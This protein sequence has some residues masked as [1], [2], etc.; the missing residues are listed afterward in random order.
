MLTSTVFWKLSFLCT[1]SNS[2]SQQNHNIAMNNKYDYHTE[3]MNVQYF[4]LAY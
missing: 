1:A 2:H 3:S 4:D